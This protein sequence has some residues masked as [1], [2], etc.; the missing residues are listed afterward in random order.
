MMKGH[1]LPALHELRARPQWV[2]WRYEQRRGKKTKVPYNPQ[3]GKL[4][5]SNDPSTLGQ[6]YRCPTC[7]RMV[8]EGERASLRW[9]RLHVPSRSYRHSTWIIVSPPMGPS[10][11]GPSPFWSACAVTVSTHQG[12]KAFISWCMGRCQRACGVDSR[13]SGMPRRPLRCTLRGATLPSRESTWST[14]HHH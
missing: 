14:L 4:A 13:A 2:C 1:D 9:D 7:L 11:R 12:R 6:L 10:I 8:T 3:T 5:A